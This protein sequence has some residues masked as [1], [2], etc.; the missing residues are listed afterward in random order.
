[1]EGQKPGQRIS[2]R[3][4]KPINYNNLNHGTGEVNANLDYGEQ[5]GSNR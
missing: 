2:E 1:M 4:K 3:A 5:S